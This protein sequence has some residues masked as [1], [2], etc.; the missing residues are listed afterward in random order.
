MLD[1]LLDFTL[2]ML[3]IMLND[4]ICHRQFVRSFYYYWWCYFNNDIV[5]VVIVVVVVVLVVATAAAETVDATAVRH[6]VTRC[7]HESQSQHNKMSYVIF[8][9]IRQWRTYARIYL[10][11]K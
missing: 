7:Q 9:I 5:V 6:F 3:D 1:I 10:L 2:D 4:D 8:N 11:T